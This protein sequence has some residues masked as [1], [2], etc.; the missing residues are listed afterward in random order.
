M[1]KIF[2]VFAVLCAACM[3]SAYENA[4]E[5]FKAGNDLRAKKKFKEAV[6]AYE[7][8]GKLAQNKSQK[9]T[10]AFLAG[11]CTCQDDRCDEGISRLREALK[12]A[13]NKGSELSCQF[14][15]GYLLGSAG[16]YE[17]A[18]VEMKKLKELAAG[19][20]HTIYIDR[21]NVCTGSYLVTLK[22]YKEALEA[23]KD[24][25]GSKDPELAAQAWDAVFASSRGLNDKEN[26]QK[27]V[28]S[29]LALK[30]KTAYA[31][32]IV[33]RRAFELAR[34][35]KKHED[36]LKYADEIAANEKLPSYLRLNGVYYQALA[37]AALG[38]KEK[39][40]AAWKLL[41]K[42]GIKSFETAAARNIKRLAPAK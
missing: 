2:T 15:I 20:P 23:V 28:D 10:G 40:L 38:D 11:V 8:A 19:T 13:P 18:I 14:H 6:S 39:E 17:E 25:C 42:C 24:S 30:P 3:L 27:A 1:K 29:M 34:M 5:A 22:R 4:A 9:F 35:Q 21:A 36:S 31:F 7:E 37:H 33:R 41:E 12:I 26:M 16:R 32:F